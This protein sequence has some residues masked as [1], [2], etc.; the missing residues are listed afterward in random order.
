MKIR[1]WWCDQKKMNVV[2]VAQKKKMRNKNDRCFGIVTQIL[3]Q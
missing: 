2:H 3:L 1:I